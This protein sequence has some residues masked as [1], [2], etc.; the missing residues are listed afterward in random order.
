MKGKFPRAILLQI[1]A[2][3]GAGIFGIPYAV[4]H[5]GL[6]LGIFYLLFLTGVTLLINLAY[7]EVIL[8]TPGDHQLTGYGRLYL[9]RIGTFLAFLSLITGAYGAILAYTTQTGKFLTLLLGTSGTDIIFG[10]L[11]FALAAIGVIL[12]LKKVSQME[13]IIV[14]GIVILILL[15]TFLGL[16]HFSKN[17]LVGGTDN[18]MV[19]L[20]PYG[21]IFFALSG[22]TVIPEMEELLRNKHTSLKKAVVWGTLIPAL[23]YLLFTLTVVGICGKTTSPDAIP[24]LIQ[25]LPTGIIKIGAL[26]GVLA[27]FS[28]FLILGY[29]LK[30]MFYRDFRMSSLLSW[31]L[32]FAP[33]LVL[34]LLGAR[35]FVKIL[36]ITGGIMGG[37]TGILIILIYLKARKVGEKEPPFALNLSLPLLVLMC[38]VF[39]GG[40]VYEIFALF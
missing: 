28:S 7:A 20:A 32:S 21:V 40:I 27:M 8:R 10:L 25:F 17:N 6:P 15:I 35:D 14:P 4:T 2:V 38:L 3:I 11:I 24:G 39:A 37:L 1:G 30:E 13:S 22:S 36:G 5:A 16:P 12:G 26:L 23:I 31:G 19:A 33:P 9:G 29:V 18:L 34:F